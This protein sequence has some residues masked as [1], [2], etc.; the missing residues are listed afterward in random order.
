MCAEFLIP[1]P[2]DHSRPEASSGCLQDNEEFASHQLNRDTWADETVK[3][4]LKTFF[5]FWQVCIPC[6]TRHIQISV[7]PTSAL[8]NVL[9]FLPRFYSLVISRPLPL[10]NLKSPP[11]TIPRRRLTMVL[12]PAGGSADST[13]LSASRL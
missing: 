2:I 9:I 5:V 12:T 10:Q 3:T 6:Y 8:P 4:M 1:F 11:P 7:G 13:N